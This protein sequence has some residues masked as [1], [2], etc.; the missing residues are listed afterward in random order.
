MTGA[1]LAKKGDMAAVYR[2][3]EKL[4]PQIMAQ[5]IGVPFHAGAAKWYK[6][7]GISVN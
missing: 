6:E 3:L 1:I 2:E 5:D 4:T 7:R